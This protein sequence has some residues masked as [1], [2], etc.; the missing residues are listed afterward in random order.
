MNFIN[1]GAGHVNTNDSHCFGAMRDINSTYL[2]L[3]CSRFR[4]LRSLLIG[5]RKSEIATGLPLN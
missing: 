4:R 3:G 1:D 5:R 2:L